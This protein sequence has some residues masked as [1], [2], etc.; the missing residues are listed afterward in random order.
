LTPVAPQPVESRS[1]L[2]FFCLCLVRH[3]RSGLT[4]RRR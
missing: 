4:K 1:D 2:A 3:W